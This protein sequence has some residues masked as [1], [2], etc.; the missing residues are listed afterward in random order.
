MKKNV[1]IVKNAKSNLVFTPGTK[2][3]SNGKS[4][5]F[6]VVEDSK[7][8]HE[9]GFG[10][11]EKRTAIITYENTLGA[12]VNYSEGHVLD[13]QIIRI[14][15]LAPMFKGHEPVIN[16]ETKAV[17]TRQGMPLYRQDIFTADQNA[18]DA[19]VA[20]EVESAVEETA[21]NGLAD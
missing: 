4:Y 3:A 18:C 2:V 21:G 16:P 19:L 13:G 14:E 20:K 9:G 7:I 10:R 11:E 6:Y 8:I 1:R 5:G 17:V 15:S 12:K